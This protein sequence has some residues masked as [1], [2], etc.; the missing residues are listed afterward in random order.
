MT[1]Q[2]VLA[3]LKIYESSMKELLHMKHL[4][5]M[6]GQAFSQTG[7][8]YMYDWLMDIAGHMGDVH[9]RTTKFVDELLAEYIRG[10]V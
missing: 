4:L 8:N 6:K 2:E 10:P 3:S 7:N 9:E 1:K 5:Q